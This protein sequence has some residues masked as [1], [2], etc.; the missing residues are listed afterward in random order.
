MYCNVAC[1][2]LL[3]P[4]LT[5]AQLLIVLYIINMNIQSDY[6]KR[7]AVKGTIHTPELL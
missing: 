4:V 1:K 3:I 2:L 6:Q 5:H 7:G